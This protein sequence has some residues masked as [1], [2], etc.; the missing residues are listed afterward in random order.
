MPM[1]KFLVERLHE[2][3]GWTRIPFAESSSVKY[4]QGYVDAIDSHYPS[5]PLRIVRIE[6]CTQTVVRETKGR[7]SVHTN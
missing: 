3:L 7:G 6:D 5:P 2:Q 4:C 1:R